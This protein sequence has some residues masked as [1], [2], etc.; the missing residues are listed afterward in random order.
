[1]AIREVCDFILHDEIVSAAT[2]YLDEV[3]VLSA[4]KLWWS[5]PNETCEESQL[6]HYDGEDKTQ[7]KIF[8]HVSDVGTDCGPFTY[9]PADLSDRV[10]STRRHSARL[11]DTAVEGLVGAGGV[12]QLLGPSGTTVAID[13]SRCL[14]YGSRGNTQER[15]VMMAQFT[16][17]LAPKAH[18][19][20]WR[21][22]LDECCIGK[23]DPIRR[24]I[25]N[26]A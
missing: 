16:R 25:F 9:V 23:L 14:H 26:L 19:P 13:T 18:L 6:Y 21:G 12:R 22:E 8:L 5:P 15:L 4:I 20:N 17:F 24:S 3:P 11:D 7:L 10:T 2:H 1:M